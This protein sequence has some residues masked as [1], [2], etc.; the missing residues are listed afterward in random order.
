MTEPTSST[1]VDEYRNAASSIR[2]NAKW[3]LKSLGGVAAALVAGLGLS[4]LAKVHSSL[5]LGL[6]VLGIAVALVGVGWL[7]YMTSE[8]LKPSTVSLGGVVAAEK[9]LTP[10]YLLPM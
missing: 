3:G 4:S 9:E 5:Y 10:K 8:I 6:A 7:Y 1:P 2:E